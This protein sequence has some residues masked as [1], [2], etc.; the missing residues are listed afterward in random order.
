MLTEAVA[1]CAANYAVAYWRTHTGVSVSTAHLLGELQSGRR[2][3]AVLLRSSEHNDPMPPSAPRPAASNSGSAVIDDEKAVSREH[4]SACAGSREP[5]KQAKLFLPST[6][7]QSVYSCC[8]Q[9]TE[10]ILARLP[11][12][13]MSMAVI[14]NLG[15]SCPADNSALHYM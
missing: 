15:W 3:A 8:L 4:A 6:S 1:G 2:N 11:G 13:D 10:H 12:H 14:C 5:G 7:K 9:Y